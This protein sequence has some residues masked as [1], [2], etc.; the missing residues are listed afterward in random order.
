MTPLNNVCVQNSLTGTKVLKMTTIG[1]TIMAPQVNGTF[2]S[3]YRYPHKFQKQINLH[4]KRNTFCIT[5]CLKIGN[6]SYLFVYL[7]M[8]S[9]LIKSALAFHT[10]KHTQS[11]STSWHWWERYNTYTTWSLWT[12][13]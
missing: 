1:D 2:S 6:I 8:Y 5:L 4:I 10:R 13:V 3:L 7:F 11:L 9:F 12:F